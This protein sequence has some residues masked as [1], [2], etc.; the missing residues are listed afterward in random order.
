M[1][2]LICSIEI[3]DKKEFHG[4]VGPQGQQIEDVLGKFNHAQELGKWTH[5]TLTAQ[6]A[7]G[8]VTILSGHICPV[9]NVAEGCIA[10]VTLAV[11]PSTVS[12]DDV[13]VSSKKFK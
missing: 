2:C 10:L 11:A 1:K 5:V 13:P 7:V 3:D 6:K 9:H 12:R 4:A 8:S